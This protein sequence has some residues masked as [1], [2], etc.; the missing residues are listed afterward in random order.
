MSIEDSYMKVIDDLNAELARLR[1]EL[2]TRE[3]DPMGYANNAY[4]GEIARLREKVVLAQNVA[5]AWGDGNND[6]LQIAL[7]SLFLNLYGQAPRNALL[8]ETT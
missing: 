5:L 8:K 3:E 6:A 4:E 2:A 7:L 1:R